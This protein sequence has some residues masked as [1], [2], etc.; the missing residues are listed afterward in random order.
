[1]AFWRNTSIFRDYSIGNTFCKYELFTFL[2]FP[3]NN[4]RLGEL[5]GLIHTV[6]PIYF[7]NVP[8]DIFNFIIHY[9]Y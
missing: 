8:F 1:M 5:P 2:A 9:F 6:K 7:T 3:L 4:R